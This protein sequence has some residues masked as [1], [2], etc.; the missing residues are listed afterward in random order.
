M[1]TAIACMICVLV[2]SATLLAQW[3]E[4]ADGIVTDQQVTRYLGAIKDIA[5]LYKAAGKAAEGQGAIGAMG[6][7]AKT[8][9]KYQ[10]I[11]AKH[12]LSDEEFTWVGG[13]VTEA[14]VHAM[15]QLSWEKKSL[16]AAQEQEKKLAAEIE[17]HKAKLAAT[18]AAAKS[19]TKVLDTE[20]RKEIVD[21]ANED[22]KSAEESLAEIMKE[23][24][25]HKDEIARKEKEAQVAENL[26]KVPPADVAADERADYIE[27]KKSEAA[28]LRDEAK[29]LKDQ[30]SDKEK[31]RAEY[32][33]AAAAAKKRAENP[34]APASDEEKAALKTEQEATIQN[35]KEQIKSSEDGLA[36]MVENR[37]TMGKQFAEMGK[38]VP[39]QN[40]EL[41]KKRY[42]DFCNA[43]GI[44]NDFVDEKK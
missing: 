38:D 34:D 33:T 39:K 23:I 21:R 37:Q 16:P 15:L 27:G 4:P 25:A 6:L 36:L 22:R 2:S 8:N 19:G 42:D 28:S 1:R 30:L 44:K 14:W 7:W 5:D 17:A 11:L 3:K 9:E 32:A 24:A 26:S 13:K 43:M 35:L 12:Q 41:L 10:A 20:A 40:I 31:T 29:D 18:E